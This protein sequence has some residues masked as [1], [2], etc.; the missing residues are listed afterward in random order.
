MIV[1]HIEGNTISVELGDTRYAVDL[2]NLSV[3]E[4]IQRDCWQ[5]DDLFLSVSLQHLLQSHGKWSEDYVVVQ[6]DTQ[7]YQNRNLSVHDMHE[8]WTHPCPEC[9]QKMAEA[10]GADNED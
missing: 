3:Q 6:G 4:Q 10:N 9:R 5:D 2:D 7:V 1:A 8:K